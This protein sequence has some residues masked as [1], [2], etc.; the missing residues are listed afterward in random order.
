M[1]RPFA[2]FRDVP[3]NETVNNTCHII[4]ENVAVILNQIN[5][6]V[7]WDATLTTEQRE[8]F[9]KAANALEIAQ[10]RM[11][12]NSEAIPLAKPGLNI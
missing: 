3:P 12:G 10:Y 4:A 1:S 7:C 8:L 11:N 6:V 5:R 9:T 2:T